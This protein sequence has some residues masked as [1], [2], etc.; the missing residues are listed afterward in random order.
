MDG[1]EVVRLSDESHHTDVSIVP[2]IGNIAYEM[3][4]NG[5]AVLWSAYEKLSQLKEKPTLMGIPLLAPWANRLDQDGYFA[6]G[7]RYLLNPGLANYR[8]DPNNQPIHGLVTFAAAWEVTRTE[9][10]ENG[11]EVTSRLDFWK[12][13]EWMAQF[14]FDICRPARF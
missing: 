9:S 14:P 4:V 7:K 3:K 11:A 13:P 10:D 2:G 1:F 8:Y 12:H 6:N 5:K